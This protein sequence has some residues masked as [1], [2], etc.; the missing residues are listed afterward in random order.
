MVIKSQ[1]SAHKKKYS[2]IF[3]VFNKEHWIE[4]IL[5]SWLDNCFEKNEI[6]VIIVF[7][8]CSDQSEKIARDTLNKYNVSYSFLFADDKR[9]IFCNNLALEIAVGERVIFIQDDN[10]IYDKNWDKTLNT[11]YYNFGNIGAIGLLSG[12]KVLEHNWKD[13]VFNFYLSEFKY[14]VKALFSKD[15]YPLLLFKKGFSYKRIETDRPHKKENFNVFNIESSG[16]FIK[17]VHV[18]NRPFVID[19]SLLSRFG[20]LRQEY[21]PTLGDDTFLS[22]QL[23]EHGYENIYAPFDLVNISV[24]HETEKHKTKDSTFQRNMYI[25]YNFF[26]K[27]CDIRKH[28]NPFFNSQKPKINIIAKVESEENELKIVKI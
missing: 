25:Q 11:I 2:L 10:W 21:M 6:E 17:N 13:D 16:M 20:N 12:I 8:D 24:S 26:H 18:I 4:S 7:D 22:L 14:N 1:D 19:K 27:I 3:T 15:K 5:C 23:I 9:E 28:F